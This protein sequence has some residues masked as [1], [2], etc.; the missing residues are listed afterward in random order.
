M[1]LVVRKKR[2]SEREVTYKVVTL[3]E[4]GVSEEV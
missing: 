3:R 2:G 4:S 1:H